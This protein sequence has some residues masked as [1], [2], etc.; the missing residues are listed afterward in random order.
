MTHA[1]YVIKTS[2]Y[3][4][5]SLYV[6]HSSV[7]PFALM[8]SYEQPFPLVGYR[9]IRYLIKLFRPRY[10]LSLWISMVDK[11]NAT[12]EPYCTVN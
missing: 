2:D 6:D 5:R 7:W 12:Y 9:R 10:Q 4:Q 3:C 1:V 11:V 8:R